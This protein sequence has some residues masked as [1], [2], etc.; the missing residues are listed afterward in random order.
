MVPLEWI[1]ERV[2]WDWAVR[3]GSPEM[4]FELRPE[5]LE[6]I[7]L[8][9]DLIAEYPRQQVWRYWNWNKLEVVCNRKNVSLTEGYYIRKNDRWRGLIRD[10]IEGPDHVGF[11]I[12]Q[13]YNLSSKSN[14]LFFKFQLYQGIIDI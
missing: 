2:T 10:W 11:Q 13:P 9:E 14:H 7:Y 3:K 1:L 6:A 4:T 8:S 5:W 12:C